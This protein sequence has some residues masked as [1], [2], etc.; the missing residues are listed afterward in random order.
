MFI[1][2]LIDRLH[3]LFNL[4]PNVILIHL[5]KPLPIIVLI[6]YLGDLSVSPF[7]NFPLLL[8]HHPKLLSFLL[9]FLPALHVNLPGLPSL[10]LFNLVNFGCDL[11]VGFLLRF[12]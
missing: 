8:A 9:V 5:Y 3:R 2:L 7:L 10:Y 4:F 12:S 1:G 6:I 11:K